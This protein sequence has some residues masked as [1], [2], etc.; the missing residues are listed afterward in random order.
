MSRTRATKRTISKEYGSFTPLKKITSRSIAEDERQ[1]W[2]NY[3][4]REYR[5]QRDENIMKQIQNHINEVRAIESVLVDE[6]LQR[7]KVRDDKE[8][9]LLDEIKLL[10]VEMEKLNAKKKLLQKDLSTI[11]CHFN[12]RDLRC[13][14]GNKSATC[15]NCNETIILETYEG[16]MG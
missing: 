12:T 8:K 7:K 16:Q 9:Q 13:H 11:C 1:K 14:R 3:L 2:E 4:D 6:Y 5:N 10:D 15:V